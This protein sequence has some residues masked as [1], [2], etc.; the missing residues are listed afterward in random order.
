[1]RAL[2]WKDPRLNQASYVVE[3]GT[4]QK[5]VTNFARGGG[6]QADRHQRLPLFCGPAFR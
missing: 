2:Q 5:M 1:M 4:V 3:L 6:G